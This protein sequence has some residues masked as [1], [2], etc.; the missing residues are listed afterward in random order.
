[1][2]GERIA[3]ALM[4]NS[5]VTAEDEVPP[6]VI[7]FGPGGELHGLR[8]NNYQ[9][10]GTWS[11]EN[12][13]V[14]GAWNNWYGTMSRCWDVYRAGDRFTLKR[15]DGST[16]VVATFAAGDVAGLQ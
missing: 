5:L 11:V 12:D 9:D 13:G 2:T 7:F 3:A 15:R 10:S 6:L 8:S 1:L 16:S 14:C 4:G